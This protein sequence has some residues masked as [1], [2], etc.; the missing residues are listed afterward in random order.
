MTQMTFTSSFYIILY[1]S[2][3]KHCSSSILCKYLMIM[4]IIFGEISALQC[5]IVGDEEVGHVI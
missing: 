1:Q 2:M 4:N 3:D 5:G